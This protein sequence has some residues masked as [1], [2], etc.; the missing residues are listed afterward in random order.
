MTKQA[1]KAWFR[2]WG[3]FDQVNTLKIKHNP[4]LSL[5]YTNLLQQ[6]NIFILVIWSLQIWF[7]DV[8]IYPYVREYLLISVSI[9]FFFI[10][11]IL[12]LELVEG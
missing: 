6:L 10:I 3:L 9:F 8:G 4:C 11:T 12:H 5:E 1:Q 7:C 2:K